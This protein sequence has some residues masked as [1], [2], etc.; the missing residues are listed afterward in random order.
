MFDDIRQQCVTM[1]DSM[2]PTTLHSWDASSFKHDKMA[3]FMPIILEVNLTHLLPT[4]L[5]RLCSV[6]GSDTVKYLKRRPDLLA[7]FMDGKLTLGLYWARFVSQGLEDA[8]SPDCCV[9]DWEAVISTAH[10]KGMESNA[11]QDP[12][13]ALRAFK[14]NFDNFGIC[15]ECKNFGRTWISNFRK[16]IWTQLPQIFQIAEDWEKL[17]PAK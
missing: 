7:Q 13:D 17:K 11:L 15:V 10:M 12:L 5:Y 9:A 3:Q 14:N 6:K 16:E 1:F 8:C 2:F 4:A